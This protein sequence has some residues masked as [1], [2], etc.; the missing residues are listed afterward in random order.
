[1]WNLKVSSNSNNC[2]IF[3]GAGWT[4][5]KSHP[6]FYLAS[7]MQRTNPNSCFLSFISQDTTT[8]KEGCGKAGEKGWVERTLSLLRH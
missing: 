6:L 8:A 1:M 5:V 3:A 2:M 4:A 7:G